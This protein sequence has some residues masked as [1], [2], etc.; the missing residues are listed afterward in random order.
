[1]HVSIYPY[2]ADWTY[3]VSKFYFLNAHCLV[4]V[5]HSFRLYHD[6]MYLA[7]YIVTYIHIHIYVDMT[8]QQLNINTCN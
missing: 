3:D 2:I 8:S 4:K 6:I 5:L 7:T 1:M